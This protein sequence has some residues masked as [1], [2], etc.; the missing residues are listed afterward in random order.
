MM[1]KLENLTLDNGNGQRKCIRLVTTKIFK[2]KSILFDLKKVNTP[3]LAAELVRKLYENIDREM[4][5]A[6]SLDSKCNPLLIEVV[7][8][9]NVNTCIVSPREVFKSAIISNA[10]HILVFHN[11]V[12]GDCAPSKEDISVTKRLIDVGNI[13][14]IPVLDHIVVGEENYFSLREE[15]IVSFDGNS[16]MYL[17]E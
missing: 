11:H 17:K 9:G 16:S 2:E 14:G 5:V 15:N 7:A 1:E 4:L 3:T 12:S 10:V 8:L 6:M 13:L